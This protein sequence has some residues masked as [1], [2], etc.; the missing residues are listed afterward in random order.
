MPGVLRELA[1]HSL[2]VHKDA[3]PVKQ[4]LRRFGNEK[5]HTIGKEIA[6]L[7]ATGF[8]IEVIHTDWL[9]NPVHVPK[10]NTKELHMCVDYTGLN[11]TCPKDLFVLPRIDQVID[12]MAGSEL[13]C[14]LDAY[15]GYHLIM[16]RESDQLK[17]FF[18]TPTTLSVT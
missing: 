11:K 16:I 15:F 17:T 1:E 13:L 10:K 18:I 8:I 4:S 9:A 12:S 3:W 7:L 6:W 14:F 5:R 2:N